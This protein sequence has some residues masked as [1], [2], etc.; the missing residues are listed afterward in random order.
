MS[1][2]KEFSLSL[3]A[4][5]LTAGLLFAQPKPAAPDSGPP[6]EV[7]SGR[8]LATSG[9]LALVPTDLVVVI[10]RSSTPQELLHFEQLSRQ[11]EGQ[12]T[13]ADSLSDSYDVGAYRLGME[14]ALA[15]KII[16]VQKTAK[17]REIQLIGIRIPQGREHEGKLGPQDYRFVVF[18]LTVDDKGNGE[19]QYY[20]SVKLRFNKNHLP[21]ID[22]Y[23]GLPGAIVKV[24]PEPVKT[25]AH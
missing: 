17:G 4:C 3:A 2:A 13:L 25:P 1:Y 8:I 22:D 5:W 12:G 23:Q 21:E 6:P 10:G 20:Q 24:H 14:L 16:T 7:Y 18:K 11:K 15:L 9:N 19:G